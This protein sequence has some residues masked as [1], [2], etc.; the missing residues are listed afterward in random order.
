MGMTC[1][2][3]QASAAQCKRLRAEPETVEE[4]LYPEGAAP[5]VV[6]VREK[7]LSGW[8]LRLMPVKV[9][10]TDPD[11]VPPEHPGADN[12]SQLDIDK[13]WHGLHFIFTGAAS[14]GEPPGCFL[15]NGGEEIGDEDDDNRPRLLDPKQVRQFSDFL[16][17]LSDDEFTR[18]YDAE[19]MTALEIYPEVIWKRDA[20]SQNPPI[21]YLRSAFHDLRAFVATAADRG[22]AIVVDVS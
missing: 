6:E 19:R 9:T 1:T 13:A 7:G 11:W 4:F 2:L 17:S 8:I 22:N 16:T 18:R 15:V 5:R 12:D 21:D 20:G 10:Q 3:R 14:E